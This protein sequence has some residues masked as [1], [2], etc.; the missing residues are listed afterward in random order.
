[1][2]GQEAA[3]TGRIE[4]DVLSEEAPISV[5]T[6]LRARGVDFEFVGTVGT[7]RRLLRVARLELGLP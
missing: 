7:G 5:P 4:D 3:P 1:M 6:V 2:A